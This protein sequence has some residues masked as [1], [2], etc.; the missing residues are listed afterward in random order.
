MCTCSLA[1]FPYMVCQNALR[2]HCV[3]GWML[4][5]CQLRRCKNQNRMRVQNVTPASVQSQAASCF[6]VN[7]KQ[8]CI[9]LLCDGHTVFSEGLYYTVHQIPS[10]FYSSLHLRVVIKLSHV[11][12]L[13]ILG[14][15]WQK[16][17]PALWFATFGRLKFTGLFLF[18]CFTHG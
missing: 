13:S 17:Y 15:K 3:R 1:G 2:L 4:A 11:S 10:K 14:S 7:T 12:F 16:C 18:C 8:F 5:V 6:Q 9:L